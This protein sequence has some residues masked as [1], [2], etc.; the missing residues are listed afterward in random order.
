MNSLLILIWLALI[1]VGL[2]EGIIVGGATAAFFSVLG[3]VARLAQLTKTPTYIYYYALAITLGASLTSLFQFLE[4]SFY[5]VDIITALVG[6]TM[7]FFIGFLAG[8]LTEVLNVIPIICRRLRME[9]YLDVILF[10]FI[11]GKVL[12]SLFYWLYPLWL[13]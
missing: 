11:L 10:F 6:L 12:G 13:P 1:I 2:S 5:Q 3:I 9:R 8:A 7:G 4:V